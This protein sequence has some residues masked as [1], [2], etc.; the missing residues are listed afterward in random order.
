MR[1]MFR[2]L[3]FAALCAALLAS[4]DDS[5]SDKHI[6]QLKEFDI[7]THPDAI[8]PERHYFPEIRA[9]QVNYMAKVGYPHTA[10][11]SQ[12][13]S[14]LAKMGWAECHAWSADW[15]IFLD[16]VSDTRSRCVYQQLGHLRKD[17]MLLSIEHI[18]GDQIVENYECPRIPTNPLQ[19]VIIAIHVY[20]DVGS[21]AKEL[22]LTCD[23]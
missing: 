22:G 8:D 9:W 20:D 17:N 1:S 21:A 5:D 7:L 4:C 6:G 14:E 2:R 10:V 11:G 18:Y 12:Q 13:R 16:K 3:A 19:T 15:Q 23:Q